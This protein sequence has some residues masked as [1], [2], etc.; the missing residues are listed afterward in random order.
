MQGSAVERS[1][2]IGSG[3]VR[4]ERRLLVY[5]GHE[6]Y[7]AGGKVEVLPLLNAVRAIERG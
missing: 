7:S 1:F 6:A 5:P 2:H 3:D 4:A